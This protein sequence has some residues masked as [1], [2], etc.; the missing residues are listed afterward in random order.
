MKNFRPP[1]IDPAARRATTSLTQAKNTCSTSTAGISSFGGQAP[2]GSDTARKHDQ[3]Y[4][5]ENVAA[6]LYGTFCQYLDPDLFQFIEPGAGTGSFY[7]LLPPGSIA[8]DIEPKAPGITEA[9]FLTTEPPRGKEIAVIGNP[10]FGK[11]ASMAVKFF[12]HAARQAAVIGFI[13]PM[14]FQKTSIIN[15]LD[16]SFHLLHEKLVPEGA[17]LFQGKKKTVTTVFQIWVRKPEQRKRKKMATKHTDFEFTK[18]R[19]ASFAIQRVGNLAGRIHRNFN[20]SPQAHYFIKA[21]VMGVE[22]TMHSLVLSEVAKRTAG[23]PSLAKTELV[24]MYTEAKR[25]SGHF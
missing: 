23:C 13:V 22:A 12:N 17:F 11:N 9:D 24:E 8:Y 6:D 10:P 15:R 3:F 14:T 25:A 21:N 19:F 20:A 1:E 7:K 16:P 2:C 5:C 4:T 18:P